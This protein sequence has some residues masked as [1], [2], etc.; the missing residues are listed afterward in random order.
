MRAHTYGDAGYVRGLNRVVN[1]NGEVVA[2]VRFTDVFVYRERR[3]QAV[4]GQE[5][6]VTEKK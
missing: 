4:A 3:W 6:M 2:T 5:T 1:A